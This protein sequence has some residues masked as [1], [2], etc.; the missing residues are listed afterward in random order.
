LF[1]IGEI[2]EI[3]APTAGKKKYHLCIC[4]VNDHNVVQFLFINS[5]DGYEAD[6]ILMD[7]E[8]KCLPK[9]PTGMSV[10]SCNIVIRYTTE[11]LK[12]YN[13]RPLGV[14]NKAIANRLLEHI[15]SSKALGRSDKQLVIAAAKYLISN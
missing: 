7:G 9:S 8:I 13:A 1:A 6:L 10:I 14:L 5:H 11:Q 15:N 3:Y 12:L 2:V 4:G